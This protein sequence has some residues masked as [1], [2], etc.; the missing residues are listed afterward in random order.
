M[1]K[2]HISGRPLARSQ[3]LQVIFQA[4][5][6]SRSVD[7]VLSGPYV[8]TD[9]PTKLE[10][11]EADPDTAGELAV[12]AGPIDEFGEQLA[13]GVGSMRAELDRI[14][15]HFSK[16]W[17]VAR[18]P[19]VDRNLLRMALYEMLEVDD[20][21]IPVII[22]ESVELAKAYGTDESAKFINGLLASIAKS[23]DAGH[24]L[25]A[26]FGQPAVEPEAADYDEAAGYDGDDD[27]G[28]DDAYGH[29]DYE[30]QTDGE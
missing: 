19:S 4:E 22:N 5:A 2:S 9:N 26:E 6:T 16:R 28:Y 1:Q 15:T 13:Q 12:T 30:S 24:D 10:G 23:I 17:D 18:M 25:V 7:D 8:L 27:Y 14:L 11:V 3:A 21:T 29:D 20:V